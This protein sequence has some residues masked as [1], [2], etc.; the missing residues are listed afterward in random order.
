MTETAVRCRAVVKSFGT[1]RALAGADL[2][3]RPGTTHAVVGENGAGKTTLMRIVA[4]ELAP[5]GG[6]VAVQGPVSLVRQAFSL[7]PELTVL[8]NIIF[9]AEPRRRFGRIDW[10][11]ARTRVAGLVERTGLEV[12][13]DREATSLPMGMQQRTEILS[14]LYRDARVMLLDEPT[15]YLV[16]READALF[17]TVRALTS[18][19][20][21][22]VFITHRLREVA[23]NC[24]AV[25]VLCQGRI[26]GTYD[27]EDGLDLGRIGEAMLGGEDGARAV[28]V[29]GR[30]PARS[31]DAEVVLRTLREDPLE[32]RAGQVLGIAGVAGNGQDE[33]VD[34]IAGVARTA[35]FGPVELVGEDV[36]GLPV[37]RRRDRGLRVVPADVR[38]EGCAPS[39]SLQ[40]NLL[41]SEV[42]ER[43]RGRLRT[44]RRRE[45]AHWATGLLKDA[46]VVHA[47]LSQ[48][49]GQLSGGN[50]QRMVLAREL[51]DSARVLVAHEPSHGVDFAAA[52]RVR[53]RIVD[54]AWSGGAALVL[55]SDLDELIEIS[56]EIAVMSRGRLVG[57][58]PRHE[59][60]LNKLAELMAGSGPPVLAADTVA[61]RMGVAAG[62]EA[63]P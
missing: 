1:V 23:E 56:D 3:V 48:P 51:D 20:M 19:G 45:A 42:P 58:L 14:V 54:F 10:R 27:R 21:T 44:V 62:E 26:A 25:T 52:A 7:V 63:T 5:D 16:P 28:P 60:S 37:M 55:S 8:E 39:A 17:E 30:P 34:H 41:T 9:G 22:V 57:R 43:F 11:T 18:E 29:I 59:V 33:L 6:D 36:S 53:R 49:A 15:A 24:D 38:A 32:L 4:G 2:H 13:L 35:A 40:D 50:M 61:G 31:P 46:G 12:P 47:R